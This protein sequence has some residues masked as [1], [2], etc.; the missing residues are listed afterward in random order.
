M[1]GLSFRQEHDDRIDLFAGSGAPLGSYRFGPDLP[2]PCFHPLFTAAGRQIAGY[3]MSDHPWHRGLWFTIKFI[4]KTN[5]WEE[6]PPFGIQQTEVHPQCRFNSP[7]S[8]QIV[9]GLLWKSEA[10]GPV[11]KEQREIVFSCLEGGTR[12]IDWSSTLLPLADLHLDRTPYTTWGGY[13][14]LTFRASRE[15]HGSSLLLP[16]GSSCAA[17]TGQPG[18]WLLTRGLV[19]GAAEARVCLGMIDH[20][21]NPRSPSPWYGKA[22]QSYDF[23]NAAFLF[24]EPMS[25]SKG[26]EMR[27]RY[28]VLFRD[29]WWEAAEFDALAQSYWDSQP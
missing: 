9:H 12:Q 1:M 8:L 20:P 5:F 6:H 18:P 23:F 21:T 26:R 2:K 22:G 14:G 13:S 15:F 27:F 11:F 29:G 16:D 7:E 19:D 24:H 17:I 25:I 3:Q 4:N 28:R 10:T